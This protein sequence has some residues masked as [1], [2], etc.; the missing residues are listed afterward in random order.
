MRSCHIFYHTFGS[1]LQLLH[2]A[3]FM[4]AVNSLD[5]SVFSLQFKSRFGCSD[6]AGN[7]VP[8]KCVLHLSLI[9]ML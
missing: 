9:S 6:T 1:F 5:K 4:K 2:T 7:A 8:L 3:S